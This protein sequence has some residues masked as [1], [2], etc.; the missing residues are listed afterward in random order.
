M[1]SPAGASYG[2]GKPRMADLTPEE[3]IAENAAAPK[4][5]TVDGFTA[6][7]HP[8]PDQIAAVKFAAT[9]ANARRGRSGIRFIKFIP[10]GAV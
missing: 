1:K 8:I 4:T 3:Q 7:Q 10:P 9:A 5:V 6:E 2:A